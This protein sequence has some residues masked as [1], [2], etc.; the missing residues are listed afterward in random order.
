MTQLISCRKMAARIEAEIAKP[1]PAY[2]RMRID[3]I[4]L[5][6]A[7]ITGLFQANHVWDNGRAAAF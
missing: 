3:G 6:S 7:K 1:V 5:K 4:F 2:A